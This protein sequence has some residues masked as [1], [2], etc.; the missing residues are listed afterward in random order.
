MPHV[1]CI[2]GGR[3]CINGVCCDTP[4]SKGRCDTPLNKGRRNTL[5]DRRDPWRPEPVCPEAG[6][7]VPRRAYPSRGGPIRPEA[8]LS[9][10]R[11]AYL[12]H[13]RGY[14]KVRT[15]TAVGSYSRAS[16]RSIGPPQGR[17]VSLISS[18][19]CARGEA[20]HSK[21]YRGTS[22]IKDSA[23]LGPYSRKMPWALWQPYR[24][25]SRIRCG[26]SENACLF[27][28]KIKIQKCFACFLKS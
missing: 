3:V 15:G 19:P 27:L 8:G 11:R 12:T 22:A 7:S 21:D 1:G 4:L 6:L 26:D 10:P 5:H 14:S 28:R 13:Y 24:G 17:Y 25:T 2:R 20:S 9:V 18:N 16:T 23:P